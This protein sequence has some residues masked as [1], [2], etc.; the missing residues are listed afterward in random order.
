M[1]VSCLIRTRTFNIERATIFI[2]PFC[3]GFVTWLNDSA[4]SVLKH[5]FITRRIAELL[6]GNSAFFIQNLST[7][8]L[9]YTDI[10]ESPLFVAEI[11]ETL[12]INN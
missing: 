5:H 10:K 8:L 2:F 9:C 11:V 12:S 7:Q 6:I 1:I 4:L 3:R